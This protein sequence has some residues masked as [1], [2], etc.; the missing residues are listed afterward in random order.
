[1]GSDLES[2]LLLD[3]EPKAPSRTTSFAEPR[4]E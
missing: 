4:G 3:L 2:G 1:M